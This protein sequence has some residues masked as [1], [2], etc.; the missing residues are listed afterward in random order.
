M[1]KFCKRI[2]WLGER[3]DGPNVLTVRFWMGMTWNPLTTAA[4][5]AL[6]LGTSNPILSSAWVRR[7]MG[8]A[9]LADGTR[10]VGGHFSAR[11]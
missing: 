7:A 5:A 3:L 4:S 2:C 1:F 8:N 11:A 9:P 10:S 6:S